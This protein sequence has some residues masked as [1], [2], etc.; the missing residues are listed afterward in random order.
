MLTPK[1]ATATSL[2]LLNFL[3]IISRFN[4]YFVSSSFIKLALELKRYGSTPEFAIN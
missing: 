3:V 1:I 2:F 4:L